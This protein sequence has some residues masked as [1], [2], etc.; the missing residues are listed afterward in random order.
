[1]NPSLSPTNRV[2]SPIHQ[3]PAW[4]SRSYDDDELQRV[5]AYFLSCWLRLAISYGH[6]PEQTTT[7]SQVPD[8]IKFG[9]TSKLIY[10]LVIFGGFFWGA[11]V[12]LSQLSMI[13]ARRVSNKRPVGD[14]KIDVCLT[15]SSR[16]WRSMRSLQISAKLQVFLQK[17]SETIF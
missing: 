12:V 10:N 2:C 11:V 13:C 8:P 6:Q 5:W 14:T 1:M 16:R 4:S 3:N 15:H 7:R 17:I 9:G